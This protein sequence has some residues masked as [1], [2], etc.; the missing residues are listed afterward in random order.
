MKTH[1]YDENVLRMVPD[2]VKKE[3]RSQGRD[4][5][6]CGYVRKSPTTKKEGVTCTHCLRAMKI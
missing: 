5:A 4:G 1:F 3:Y 6:A 2:Y